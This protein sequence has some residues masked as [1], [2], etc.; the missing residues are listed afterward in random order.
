MED[1]KYTLT[2][3]EKQLRLIAKAVE[4]HSRAICGQIEESFSPPIHKELWKIYESR[5]ED[6]FFR[7]RAAVETL[8]NEVKREIWGYS[9]GQGGGIGY[10][11]E[12]DLGYEMYKQILHTFEKERQAE[13]DKKGEEYSWNVHTSEPL[14]LTEEPFIKVSLDE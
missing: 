9:P 2:C 3:N 14:K 4:M 10:D 11:D 8:L 12:A 6:S 7:K 1:K 13:C 5:D